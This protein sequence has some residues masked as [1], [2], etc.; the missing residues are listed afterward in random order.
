MLHVQHYVSA[1]KGHANSFGIQV[2]GGVMQTS[3]NIHNL[4][5]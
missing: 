4:K 1:K 3:V 2:I 5:S